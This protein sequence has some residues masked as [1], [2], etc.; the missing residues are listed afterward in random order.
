MHAREYD[1]L[2]RA[3]QE[4]VDL[5]THAFWFRRPLDPPPPYLSELSDAIVRSVLDSVCNWFVLQDDGQGESNGGSSSG[6]VD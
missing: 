5:A 2:R 4:G 3:V 6:S 1:V